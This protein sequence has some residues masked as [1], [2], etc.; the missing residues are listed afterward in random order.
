MLKYNDIISKLTDAQKIRILTGVGNLE[1][2]DLT[3][4]GIPRLNVGNI[5]DYYRKDYPHATALAHSWDTDL[6]EDVVRDKIEKMAHEGVNFAIVPGA[7]IKFSPYRRELTEDP[8]LAAGMSRAYASAAEKAGMYSAVAGYYLTPL[9]IDWMDKNPNRQAICDFLVKPY[10]ESLSGLERKAVMSDTRIY[11]GSYKGVCSYIQD[12]MKPNSD[13]IICPKATDANTV[14]FVSKGI[15][16][17]EGSAGA[18]E[19]ALNKYKKIKQSI[20]RGEG[21]TP[22][23]LAEAENSQSAISDETV[24]SAL[25]KV[26]DFVF[27]QKKKEIDKENTPTPNEKTTIQSAIGSTVLLKNEKDIL[28]LKRDLKVALV[29][30][31][32]FGENAPIYEIRDILK[33]D[34]YNVLGC[35]RAY[36]MSGENNHHLEEEA[37]ALV[38]SSDVVVM[39]LGFGHE[40][41]RLV[42]KA[43][44]LALPANQI[45]IADKLSRMGKKI[46]AVIASG[47]APDVEFTRHFD[48]V[49]LS[50]LEINV[51]AK[52]VAGMLSGIFNPSGK[53]AYTVYAGTDVAFSK[54]EIYKSVYGMKTGPFI[55]YRYYDTAKMRVGYPFGHGLSYTTFKYSGLSVSDK[56]VS[57]KLENV[58]D[59]AGAEIV[60]IYASKK[61]S[62]ILR[63]EKEL[64]GFKK[65]RLLPGEKTTVEMDISLPRSFLGGEYAVEDGEYTIYVASSVCDIRL[66]KNIK[67]SGKQFV[68]VKKKLSDYFQTVSNV[69]EDNYTL[70]ANYSLMKR[71]IK[72]ILFGV[73]SLILAVSMAIFN[74]ML[75]ETSLFLGVVTGVLAVSAII[76]FIC[77]IADRNRESA[78]ERKTIDEK[79]SAQFENAEEIPNLPSEAMFRDE[80]DMVDTIVGDFD[81]KIEEPLEDEYSQ[82][83]DPSLNIQTAAEQFNRFALERGYKFADGAVEKLFASLA[84]TRLVITKGMSEENFNTL[85]LLLSEYFGSGVFIDTPDENE[86]GDQF[87][88][89]EEH[90]DEPKK[91]V[92]HALSDAAHFREKISLAALNDATVASIADYVAPFLQYIYSPK[93]RTEVIIRQNKG[94]RSGYHISSNLWFMINMNETS[95]V[96][97][98]PMDIARVA[99]VN[100]MPH[101]MVQPAETHS[102][103]HGFS[104]YQI[105]YM[106]EK[107]GVGNAV[108]E[109]YWKKVDKLEKYASDVSGYSIKNKLWI[110]FER[111]LGLL[112]SAG[113]EEKDAFDAALATKILPSLS[114]SIKG[115]LK[116]DEKTLAESIEF[117]FGEDS[118]DNCKMFIDNLE[119]KERAKKVVEEK[120][121]TVPETAAEDAAPVAAEEKSE[122]PAEQNEAVL[123]PVNEEPAEVSEETVTEE[124]PEATEESASEEQ[125][126]T[127]EKTEAQGEDQ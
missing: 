117:I 124:A 6:I 66:S 15:I 91:N 74:S 79:N 53:L 87:F 69:I 28:P 60:Q 81:D 113:L 107:E 13:F 41:E 65:I 67:A 125:N 80:F 103:I 62:A 105:D 57:F 92:L 93:Y 49:M 122:E 35:E 96:D 4:L 115:K 8:C 26:L 106:F 101:T 59:V 95:A 85:M 11:E 71:S 102:E 112:I 75:K 90:A 29:G 31:I 39:F 46:V 116:K 14:E 10:I 123:E 98:L 118:I 121:E 48:A 51:T 43:E 9:D 21:A 27:T 3:I 58:G 36:S 108:S 5:K 88:S 23:Q 20:E 24:D 76:F 70:E 126:T 73:G 54:R 47:H 77:E 86:N 78:E 110:T 18:L 50:P 119:V 94:L 55:G 45:Y 40:R 72:N 104:S 100:F 44:D 114:A 30:D 97:A 33:D 42:P 17:L 82:F 120:I 64:I 84:S 19:A 111:H 52:A 61:N 38:R 12:R 68:P 37:T 1:G 32:L 34:G 56:K 99:A 89:Y 22:T 63:P 7:K 2:K 127:E 83:I 16:C 109:E 25:D